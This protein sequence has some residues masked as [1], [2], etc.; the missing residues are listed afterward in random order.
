MTLFVLPLSWMMALTKDQPA[1]LARSAERCTRHPADEEAEDQEMVRLSPE[2]FIASMGKLRFGVAVLIPQNPLSMEK[3]PPDM[4]PA[5][6]WP[7]M[8]SSQNP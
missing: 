8:L 2:S 7:M 6:G 1:P 5:S 4:K 3:L